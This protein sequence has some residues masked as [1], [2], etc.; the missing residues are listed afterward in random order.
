MPAADDEGKNRKDRFLPVAGRQ[1]L[2]ASFGPI[3]KIRINVAESVVDAVQR[4]AEQMG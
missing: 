3:N 1:S 4:L 2:V